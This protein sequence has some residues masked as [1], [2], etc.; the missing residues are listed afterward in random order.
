LKFNAN[1][2]AEFKN[3]NG[4]SSNE[5]LFLAAAVLLVAMT[6]ANATTDIHFTNG[7]FC[8]AERT[9]ASKYTGKLRFDPMGRT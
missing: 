8:L 5:K 9:A 4:I 3:L 6:A 7:E 2:R 1:Q